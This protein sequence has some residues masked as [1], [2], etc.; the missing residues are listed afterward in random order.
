MGTKGALSRHQDSDRAS[1]TIL[2]NVPSATVKLQSPHFLI[3]PPS[4]PGLTP[5]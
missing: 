4:A 2:F 3:Q 1:I 5:A